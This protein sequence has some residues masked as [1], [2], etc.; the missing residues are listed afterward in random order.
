MTARATSRLDSALVERGLAE[1]PAKAQALVLAG[2]VMVDG[3]IAAKAAGAVRAN[4]EIRV[5]QRQRYVS[6]GGLK[7]E[8]ALDAFKLDVADQTALDVGASTGGFTDCL[9]QRG[10]AKVIAVDVGYGQL[11]W[12][13]RND[14]R[15]IV[16]D[17]TN[18]RYLERLPAKPD[19]ATIDVSFISLE[20]VLPAVAKLLPEDGWIIALVKPQFEAGREQVSKGGV[21]RQPEVHQQVLQKVARLAISLGYNVLGAVESPITGP[22]GNREFFLHL[23]RGEGGLTP[24]EVGQIALATEGGA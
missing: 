2:Q 20:I 23:R 15:V 3:Q 4:A 6:R 13:L 18:I 14:P 12:R 16:V 9:L 17:R 11:D 7:L 24:D 19:G 21:V 5:I 1:S 22:A 8:H 10:A